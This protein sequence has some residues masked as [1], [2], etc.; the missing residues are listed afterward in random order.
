LF[1][2]EFKGFSVFLGNTS[3]YLKWVR[4][5]AVVTKGNGYAIY[6]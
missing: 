2:I 5:I 6:L 4:V 3:S 1:Y